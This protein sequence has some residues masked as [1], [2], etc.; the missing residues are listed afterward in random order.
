MEWFRSWFDSPYY[1]ILYDNRND[2]E[3]KFFIDNLLKYYSLNQN[4]KILDTCCGRGR[5][6]VYL[7]EQGFDVTG[8]DLSK[9]SIAHNKKSECKTLHFFVHDIRNVFRENHFD[10]V[11]NLF[12]SF[13]YFE[14]ETENKKTIQSLCAALRPGGLLIIDFMNVRHSIKNMLDEEIIK[15]RNIVFKIHRKA[16]DKFIIKKIEVEEGNR[17][18]EFMEKVMTL[19]KSDFENYFAEAGLKTKSIFGNYNLERFDAATSQRMI[20]VAEKIVKR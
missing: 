9:S 11:L 14:D 12:S 16:E 2:D 7:S 19:N 6:S 5:H 4:T 1:H 3:A 20:L 18:M 17:K 10:F 13:G 15:I 8:F